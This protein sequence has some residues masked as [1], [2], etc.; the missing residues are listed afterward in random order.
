MPLVDLKTDLTSLRFGKPSKEGNIGDR[1]GGGFSREPFVKSKPLID[2]IA[3]DG[4][5]TLANTGGTDMFIRGEGK[6]ASSIEKDLER[7]GKYFTTTEGGL[8]AVQQN[9]LSS[10][11]VRIYGGYPISVTTPNKLRLND[12]TYLPLGL[13]TL[14]AAAGVAFGDH[15]NKQGIDF[16]GNSTTL[17]RPQYINLVKGN[18]EGIEIKA[19]SIK[20]TYN[21]RLVSLY[22]KK[23]INKG[24]STDTEL[25][26]YLGGPQAGKNG[27]L[28]TTIKTASDRTFSQH[29]DFSIGDFRTNKYLSVDDLT[30][31]IPG[32]IDI[33]TK[34]FEQQ[35]NSN[36]VS[37]YDNKLGTNYVQRLKSVNPIISINQNKNGISYSTYA[38]PGLELYSEDYRLGKNT[39]IS[40]GGLKDFRELLANPDKSNGPTKIEGNAY[41]TQ[42]IEQRVNLGNP[43]A[44]GQNRSDFTRG[45]PNNDGGL[46]KINSLYLYK[47]EAVTSNDRKN[48]LVKFRIAVI[49]NDNP[50]LKTFIHFRAFINSFSDSMNASWNSFKY[51]GRGEDFYTYQGFNNSISMGFTVAV[52]SIQELSVVYQKLNY[53]K[54]SL[55]PD[56]SDEGYMRGN[57]HQ[58]TFGGYFYE[59]PGIIE[60]L[61]YTIPDG[62]PYEIGIPSNFENAETAPDG[63]SVKTNPAVKEL[64]LVINVEMNFKPIYNFLPETIGDINGTS[65]IKQR[66][67]SL[68]NQFG[69]GLYD[70]KI[71]PEFK[72]KGTFPSQQKSE[73]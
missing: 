41:A 59:V 58:L 45:N 9:L 40:N 66:F 13:S 5:E 3:Q 46:D 56:Y 29:E 14:A 22:R 19:S 21:N 23:I 37:L 54:S 36:I 10:T 39:S 67:I 16:T 62:T 63:S 28:K 30:F 27:N 51:T 72:V 52:Q 73:A 32:G 24:G 26:S 57:I 50:S 20:Q 70:N 6:V 64:P 25:Y 11:G 65:N 7:L 17:S 44:R 48:D 2:R 60:S 31:N 34:L 35:K 4:T 8:F 68:S 38:Q 12:G 15:P 71:G 69:A 47:S 18:F 42:N 53:L 55:A 1:P 33:P 43:G 49:D 61:T